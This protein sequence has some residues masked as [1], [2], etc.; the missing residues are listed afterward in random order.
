VGT[1]YQ[2]F[3]GSCAVPKLRQ[4]GRNVCGRP[5]GAYSAGACSIGGFP[6]RAGQQGA[7]TLDLVGIVDQEPSPP[8]ASSALASTE[9]PTLYLLANTAVQVTNL[10]GSRLLERSTVS[11]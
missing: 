10:S 11:V 7:L 3:V 8:T 4:P 5:G 2:I 1:T 9:S 6:A